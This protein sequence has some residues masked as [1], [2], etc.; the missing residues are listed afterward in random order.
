MYKICIVVLVL[1]ISSCTGDVPTSPT[2]EWEGLSFR[3]E[4]RP[5]V[6]RVG[7]VEFL[8]VANREGRK[9]AWDLLVKLRLGETG[10]WKQAIEDGNMGV[11]RTALPVRDPQKDILSLYIRNSKQQETVLKIPLNYAQSALEE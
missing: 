2:Q 1:M 8:V 11:Y 10:Q 7:M 3:V 6:P 5:P 4:T 9:P